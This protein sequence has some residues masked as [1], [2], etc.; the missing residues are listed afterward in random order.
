MDGTARAMN[1]GSIF[2]LI[3]FKNKPQ[4]PERFP[5]CANETIYAVI[6]AFG[7]GYARFGASLGVDVVIS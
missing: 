2:F 1:L 5:S 3:H 7:T 4:G 6:R